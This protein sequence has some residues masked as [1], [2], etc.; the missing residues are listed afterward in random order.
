M[1]THLHSIAIFAKDRERAVGFYRE[2]LGFEMTA[3]VTDPSNA[4]NR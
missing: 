3:D 1:V 2:A 4:E